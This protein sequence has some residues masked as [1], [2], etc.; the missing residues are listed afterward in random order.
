MFGWIEKGKNES[1]FCRRMLYRRIWSNGLWTQHLKYTHRENVDWIRM[2]NKE[3]TEVYVPF[4]MATNVQA[5]RLVWFLWRR[6]LL[7]WWVESLVENYGGWSTTGI[8]LKW[9]ESASEIYRPQVSKTVHCSSSGCYIQLVPRFGEENTT[10]TK[11]Q[12]N[13][14]NMSLEP[15]LPVVWCPLR[16]ILTVHRHA[17]TGVGWESVQAHCC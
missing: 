6:V 5:K 1:Q 12:A 7:K 13:K 11:K 15:I 17:N 4:D 8:Q 10:T 9:E 14:Q 3:I 16:T 2:K